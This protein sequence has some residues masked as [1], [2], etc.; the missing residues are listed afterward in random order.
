M[1]FLAHL[2]LS[3]QDDDLLLGNYVADFIRNRH[4]PD[5][6]PKVRD[7]VFLH[8]QIDSFTD[9]HPLVLRGVRRLYGDHRKYAPVVIDVFYDYL[10]A[11]HFEKYSK[12]PLNGFIDSVYR[13]LE[14]K[15][16]LL[17]VHL[18]QR[19][20]RMIAEDWLS[21]Y[22]S[23]AGLARAF[24]FMK[25]RVSQ[26]FRLDG[27]IES[28]ERDLPALDREFKGFFPEVIALVEESGHC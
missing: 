7:G 17:P 20:T 4:L 10:L 16:F 6:P 3:C 5:Y 26:P 28:L 11:R 21:G 14:R 12:E 1:N 23:K 8:R 22:C 2:F 18:Q 25:G 13:R 9:Q 19:L 24:Q 15:Q 27:A